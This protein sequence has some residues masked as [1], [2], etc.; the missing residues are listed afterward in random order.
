[1]RGISKSI[2]KIAILNINKA[3]KNINNKL[4]N[5]KINPVNY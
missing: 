4:I 1:M 5:H 2:N 3:E